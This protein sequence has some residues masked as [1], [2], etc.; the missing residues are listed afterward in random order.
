MA[1]SEAGL[2]IPHSSTYHWCST[3]QYVCATHMWSTRLWECSIASIPS[4][5]AAVEYLAPLGMWLHSQYTECIYC[6]GSFG[7]HQTSSYSKLSA[8]LH[9][10][11]EGILK[12]IHLF[13]ASGAVWGESCLIRADS[14]LTTCIYSL[15]LLSVMWWYIKCVVGLQTVLWKQI[16]SGI[17]NEFVVHLDS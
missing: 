15:V 4:A 7:Q 6:I 1:F 8:G 10:Y 3:I 11:F 2:D 5:V 9:I 12:E 13:R 14:V 16:L 17:L